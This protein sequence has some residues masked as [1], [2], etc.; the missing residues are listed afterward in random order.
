MTLEPLA[1]VAEVAV[2][3]AGFASIIVVFGQ[4]ERRGIPLVF[5]I[6]TRGML[7]CSLTVVFAAFIPYLIA[8]LDLPGPATWRWSCLVLLMITLALLWAAA[9]DGR[10]VRDVVAPKFRW[11]GGLP[12]LVAVACSSVGS[13]GAFSDV[14]F[15]AALLSFLPLRFITV[16]MD[17]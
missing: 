10:K 12:L 11:L 15:F 3:F 5:R 9:R 7:L 6:A 4:R 2:A 1:T 13:L 17:K 16:S 8:R 14:V